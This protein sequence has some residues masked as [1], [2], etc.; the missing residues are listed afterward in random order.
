MNAANPARIAPVLI[1]LDIAPPSYELGDGDGLE[2]PPRVLFGDI[3]PLPAVPL[4]AGMVTRVKLA[5]VKRVELLAWITMERLPKNDAG[6]LWVDRYGSRKL[7]KRNGFSRQSLG[8]NTEKRGCRDKRG[9]ELTQS[10]T[11]CV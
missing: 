3:V 2:P 4:V 5:Q 10:G 8:G 9:M 6:P 1:I 7:C 11:G